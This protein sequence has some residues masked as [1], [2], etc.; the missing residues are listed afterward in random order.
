[1]YKTKKFEPRPL[2]EIKADINAMAALASDLK[3]ESF[4]LNHG[5]RITREAI[6]SLLEREPGL[7]YHPGAD[8]L[9]QWLAAGGKTAFIQDGNSMI[10]K[11]Q[12]LVEALIYLK[13][14]FPSICRITTYARVRTIAQRSLE[15]L[16]AIRNAGLDRVH[17]G[18]ETGDN[19]L[20]KQIK[21]GVNAQD[22]IQGG[23]KAMAAGFQ[24]SEYWMPG[25]GGKKISNPHADGTA[26][27]LNAVN[28]HYIRSRPFRLIPGTPIQNQVQKGEIVPLTPREMLLELKRMISG[29]KVTS[30]VC[31]D[32]MGNHWRTPKG[33]LVFTHDYEGYQFPD[34]KQ[35]VL[36]RIDMGLS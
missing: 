30:K 18:L 2:H 15:S 13:N 3:S 28:P 12:D 36:E 1:M 10:M 17:L 22:Q 35:T 5:G 20:L 31:F 7:E 8:M 24:V 29:L 26:R 27:V 14:T 4:R 11:P 6:L 19:N 32:H 25:L 34:E 16:K 21:K 33:D 9:I 23:Q